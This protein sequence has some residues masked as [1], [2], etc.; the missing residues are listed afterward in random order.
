VA[1][2]V[3]QLSGEA[4]AAAGQLENCMALGQLNQQP[5]SQMSQ[6]IVGPAMLQR[7][8]RQNHQ[9]KMLLSNNIIQD[10]QSADHSRLPRPPSPP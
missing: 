6:T 4:V 8:P 5:H 3:P 7:P 1:G 2:P 10:F 9:F